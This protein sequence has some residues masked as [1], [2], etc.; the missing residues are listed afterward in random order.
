MN[1]AIGTAGTTG[2]KLVN[3]YRAYIDACYQTEAGAAYYTSSN[4]ADVFNGYDAVWDADDL[5]A[6]LRCVIS[7]SASLVP[8]GYSTVGIFSRD[9]SYDR[10]PDLVRLAGI[11]Y[12]ERGADSRYEYTYLTSNG[13][14]KDMR[15]GS[16]M[17]TAVEKM[18]RLTQEG[19]VYQ[20]SSASATLPELKAI[21]DSDTNKVQG[22]MMYDYNQTQTLND[23]YVEDTNL[24]GTTVQDGYDFAPIVTN[25][26]RWDTN[27]DGVKSTSEIMRFTE[28]WRSVKSN[29]WVVNANVANDKTKLE[30]VLKLID[31]MYSNDGQILMTYG[32]MADKDGKNGFWYNEKAT[33]AEIA[34]GAY[35]TYKG[36]KYSGTAY[37]GGAT[38][39]LT[40][41][42][43]NSFKGYEVNGFKVTDDTNLSGCKLNFT[44]YARRIIGSC[45][46]IGIVKDQ[47][48]ENQLTSDT[49]KDGALKVAAGLDNGTIKHVTLSYGT[50]LWYS[51]MTSQLP[52]T[53]LESNALTADTQ[54]T[55]RSSTTKVGS[56]KKVWSI[57]TEIIMNGLSSREVSA[58]ADQGITY[59]VG[60]TAAD[61]ATI[62]A[63]YG[64]STRV[65]QFNSAWSRLQTYAKKLGVM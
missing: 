62:M 48:F 10:T 15:E 49:G 5:T 42:T 6:I 51:S 16:G 44:N 28:S 41:N 59:N 2:E 46:P 57:Y 26:A 1:A 36:T 35:F 40:E 21:K 13:T 9:A 11:L 30:R 12:G 8:E 31:Y 33:S 17:F 34:A 61:C 27:D 56:D 23:F 22:F 63:G 18:N 14:V 39:T 24:T 38:P 53:T 3:L 19:L 54:K 58:N 50:D 52:F 47:G 60:A 29:G 32:P 4:R 55:L 20:L 64:I 45:L 65:A 25:V 43:M 7:N 37:K